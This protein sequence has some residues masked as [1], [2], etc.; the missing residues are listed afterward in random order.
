M[1]CS[2]TP[3]PH[4]MGGGNEDTMNC[5]LTPRPHAMGGGNEDTMSCCTLFNSFLDLL[6][7]LYTNPIAS[8]N[9]I[10]CAE[11]KIDLLLDVGANLHP[12]LPIFMCELLHS[13][14]W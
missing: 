8:Y 10:V 14:A 11:C 1:S 3:R 4:V 2:L 9:K 7:Q 13:C 5:S 6:L 12:Q